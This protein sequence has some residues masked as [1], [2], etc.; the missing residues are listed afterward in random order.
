[1]TTGIFT[2]SFHRSLW[3]PSLFP[4][5]FSYNLIFWDNYTR[6]RNIGTRPRNFGSVG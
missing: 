4:L 3:S 1:V 6:N 5:V 2:P